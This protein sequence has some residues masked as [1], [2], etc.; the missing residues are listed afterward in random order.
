MPIRSLY[1]PRQRAL[2]VKL[3]RGVMSA[4]SQAEFEANDAELLREPH[5]SLFAELDWMERSVP[6]NQ[7]EEARRLVDGVFLHHLPRIVESRRIELEADADALRADV[8]DHRR[9]YQYLS[10]QRPEV[11]AQLDA[12]TTSLIN[13]V[14]A[15]PATAPEAALERARL[16]EATRLSG[17]ANR[18]EDRR[19]LTLMTKTELSNALVREL[20]HLSSRLDAK[21]FVRKHG[22][23][24]DAL[25]EPEPTSAGDIEALRGG[26]A[27]IAGQATRFELYV[28]AA[29]CFGLADELAKLDLVAIEGFRGERAGGFGNCG[30]CSMMYSSTAIVVL[31]SGCPGLIDPERGTIILPLDYNVSA[32]PFCGE[33]ARAEAAS[34]FYAKDRGAVI[35]NA[36]R[37]GMFSE[38][39]AREQHR[40]VLEQLRSQYLQRVDAGERESFERAP[41]EFTYSAADF[42]VAI[43]MGTTAPEEHVCLLVTHTDGSGLLVDPTKGAL[44]AL[45]R[46]EMASRAGPGPGITQ[47]LAR[48]QTG[49]TGADNVAAAMALFAAK[50]VV[51]S[52]AMLERLYARFP[53]DR[54][55]RRNLAVACFTM[56]DKDA[57]RALMGS[58]SP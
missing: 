44:I 29:T 34:M 50:D 38:A 25:R 31:D 35:Y 11:L 45:T 26:L 18:V 30:T 48:D 39:Q 10:T 47:M 8:A 57:A 51:N 56:G 23:T 28:L 52:R 24:F 36:P 40:P 12:A 53:D 2:N 3:I 15:Q 5:P 27:E 37:M 33:E 46:A 20:D 13:E 21:Q 6:A 42:L 55:I 58:T 7:T 17:F 54:T 49:G 32:C 9:F 43:Q 22:A 16:A 41:E 19:W 4:A 1:P 14:L